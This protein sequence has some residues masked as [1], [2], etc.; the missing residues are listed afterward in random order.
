MPFGHKIMRQ[1]S[2]CVTYLPRI[3]YRHLYFMHRRCNFMPKQFS[4][5]TGIAPLGSESQYMIFL[6]FKLMTHGWIIVWVLF[7]IHRVCRL[8]LVLSYFI[9]RHST[10]NVQYSLF[11]G[12]CKRLEMKFK[13][14][15][16][17][18]YKIINRLFRPELRRKGIGASPKGQRLI[19]EKAPAYRRK[20]NGDSSIFLVSHEVGR[21]IT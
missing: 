4:T 5:W 14:L 11:D 6:T 3:P 16:K 19:A 17:I 12:R 8:C 2:C 9:M 10:K 7:S 15:F 18:K 21:W 13:I 20:S 1:E